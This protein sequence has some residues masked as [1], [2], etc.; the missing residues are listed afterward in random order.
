V[1][2]YLIS[3]IVTLLISA[4]AAVPGVIDAR[5]SDDLT[6]EARQ[7]LG[8]QVTAQARVIGDPIFQL[9]AGNVPHLDVDLAGI[10][11]GPVPI[12]RLHV[13]LDQVRVNTWAVLAHQPVRLL[14]PAP[15]QVEV[16]LARTDLQALLDRAL[17]RLKPQDFAIDLPLVGHVQPAVSEAHVL[18]E[19]GRFAVSGQVRLKPGSAPKAFAASI[20]LGVEGGDRLVAIEPR[21]SLGGQAIPAFLLGS[22]ARGLSLISLHDLQ[23][24]PGEWTLDAPTIQPDGLVLRMHG[25]LQDLRP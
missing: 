22:F 25:T 4:S 8:P 19:D 21:L 1:E 2:A 5:L 14:A 24:P 9:P 23:L 3:L 6:R 13:G 17:A 18:L 20:G 16:R 15:A 7:H 10:S 11:A 12:S